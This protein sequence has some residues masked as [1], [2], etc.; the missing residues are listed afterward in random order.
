MRK[1]LIDSSVWISYFKDKNAHKI[2]DELIKNNQICTNN[3]ILSELIPFLKYK[4]EDEIIE[5]LF[6]LD[7]IPITINWELIM[8]LQLQNLKN[9]INKVGIQDLVI[10]DNVINN[11]LI[12]FT[13]DK[14]FLLMQKYLKYDLFKEQET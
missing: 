11:S 3:L 13:E 2:L 10:L 14:H 5:L 8:N 4:G 7:N 12:L 6:D 9:G 1:I